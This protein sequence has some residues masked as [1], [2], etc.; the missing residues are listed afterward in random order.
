M[1]NDIFSSTKLHGSN[2]VT[3]HNS[4]NTSTTDALA[5]SETLLL[6][7]T[8]QLTPIEPIYKKNIVKTPE[9]VNN[10]D[11]PVL[12][13][14]ISETTNGIVISNG[15]DDDDIVE[16]GINGEDDNRTTV[17]DVYH[18]G[19][20]ALNKSFDVLP[21][22]KK[23]DEYVNVLDTTVELPDREQ[24]EP[25]VSDEFV[26]LSPTSTTTLDRTMEVKNEIRSPGHERLS[27]KVSVEYPL[28]QDSHDPPNELV[29]GL[30]NMTLQS[31]PVENTPPVS[32]IKPA[33]DTNTFVLKKKERRK[34]NNEN[35]LN[36]GADD[37]MSEFPDLCNKGS[38]LT[39]HT[40]S[41]EQPPPALDDAQRKE[42]II[43]N[44]NEMNKSS[45][46]RSLIEHNE[47]ENVD[48]EE[49]KRRSLLISKH[50]EENESSSSNV[51]TS[52]QSAF[53]VLTNLRTI[54]TVEN[55][56]QQQQSI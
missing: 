54:R 45:L 11:N 36:L 28:V 38:P 18:E 40:M 39:L 44:E 37:S 13:N 22:L 3:L 50:L 14:A 42:F 9:S 34:V 25:E 55:K 49:K 7:E 47:S 29:N 21:L 12:N 5:N 20:P 15:N 19:N 24:L 23:E 48:D 6:S 10:S 1:D 30:S 2:D 8:E 26:T 33:F 31:K 32:D 27:S 4:S 41:N 52:L 46:F 16:N 53:D 35:S 43:I 56:K 17:D 51:L